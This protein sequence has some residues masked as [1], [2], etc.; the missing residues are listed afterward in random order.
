[1]YKVHITPHWNINN[2]AGH[3]LDMSALLG[4]LS[5][6]QKTGSIAQAAQEVGLSYRYA[7]GLLRDGE[8]VFKDALMTK[9]RG[10]GTRLTPLAEKLIWA[11]RRVAARLSP[12]LESLSSELETELNKNL[13]DQT[14]AIRLH[15]SHGFAVASLLAILNQEQF[16]VE[17]QYRNSTDAVAALSRKECDLAG[18][19]IPLG[20]FEPAATAQFARW[21]NPKTHCLIHLAVRSQGLFVAQGNP[22]G[23]RDISDL[24]KNQLNFVN[25]QKGSGTR[26]LLELILAKN[27]IDPNQINGY[28]TTELTHSAVAAFIASGM[29]E[30]GFGVQTA[31]QRFGLDFIPLVR[32]RY[33]LALS[34]AALND[35][36]MQHVISVLQSAEYREEVN[37]L[38][39]YDATETGKILSISEIF[40]R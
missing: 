9:T 8:Q 15:A 40:N 2:S 25:R 27:H 4:L 18:F 21:L 29:A 14:R 36:V 10:Q 11:D 19:H 30:V 17:T 7:W 16:P 32:E 5:S 28:D 35:P 3:S 34:L 31:A 24:G 22:K 26:M 39:G 13:P 6:I 33:F 12:T 38:A 20:E 1:M 23:V 37:R